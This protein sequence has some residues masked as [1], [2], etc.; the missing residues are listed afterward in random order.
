VIGQTISHYR[1]VEK[2]GGGGMGVVYK[3]EDVTLHRF[4]ALKFLSDEVRKDPQSLAR[5]QREAQAASA[6]NHPNIC[7]IHEIGQGNGQSFIVMEFLEGMTLKHRIAGK[8]IETDV[9]LALAIEVAD[10]LDTAHGKGIVHRDVKPA[11]IFIT[12]RGHAKILDFG[13]AKV[14]PFGAPIDE[15]AA[16]TTE[17]TTSREY[18]TSPGT[19]VGTIAY[20]S[21]EQVR[22]KELDART[23]LF[24]FGTVL[25][26]M[27]TGTLPFRGESAGVIFKAILDGTPTSP[28]RL[29]PDLPADLERI[30]SKCLEKNRNL[31]YQHA[32]E[33]RTDLQR[34]KRDTESTRL[35]AIGSAPVSTTLPG[36]FDS[37]AVLP[38]VNATGDPET[39]YL[40]D[41]ISESVINLLSQLPN[42]RVIPRTS[43]FRYKGHEVDLKTVGHDLK[44][45]T[46]LTGKM[47]QRGDRL[48]VQTELVDVANDAQLWGGQFNRK[49]EDIF[50]VQE[51]LAREIS[52]G[53]RLRLT[54]ED[55]KRLAKRPTQNRDAYLFLLKAQYHL[56]RPTRE[57]LQRGLAYARQAIEADPGYG[58][59]YAWM[60]AAYS[61]LGMF[62]FVPPGETFPRAKATAQKALEIDDSLA[63]AHAFLGHA[64]LYYE[65]DWSGAEA[66]LRRALEL[67]P[68]FAWGHAAWSDWLLV[69]GRLEEAIAEERIAVELDPLSAGL[70]AR[71]GTKL[72]SRGDYDR[73]LEQLQKALEFD[74]NLEYTNYSLALTYARKEMYEEGLAACQ[75]VV[76]L[77]GS[78]PLGRA[79][80]CLVLALAGKTDEA[81]KIL[82]ELKGHRELHS[83]SL[84]LLAQTCSVMGMKTQAFEF[85]DVAYQERISWLVFLA[86]YPNFKN[87]RTDRR[88]ADLLR[89]MGLPQGPLP[90]PS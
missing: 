10:A 54:S 81:Q 56:N 37:L 17:A 18:L 49:L 70:N 90:K 73:A 12:K 6:L 11:N 47:I 20:M 61:W 14:V 2:L 69:M 55:E 59:A 52:E 83:R 63:E 22:A 15:A 44:V 89:R 86:V 71:L 19:A 9:L 40:S 27:A 30:I 75:K 72:A 1:I 31:R 85:L 4:V 23:D 66:A 32:S 79:L 87:I 57:N 84:I 51:E 34:L 35:A 78:D 36:T 39:A 7:T 80:S 8:P 62:D 24:S 53:L 3:A 43:A 68:N 45:R 76:T 38:L 64:R 16:V 25:Y 88:Y 50:E 29:N 65:W 82:S 41:G 26:E 28:V 21:P 77:C 67:N 13:L 48:V 60:S 33:L 42:L 74:P 58:E 46:V 5:F